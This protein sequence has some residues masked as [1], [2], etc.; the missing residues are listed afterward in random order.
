MKS[1]WEYF[2]SCFN[3]TK[4]YIRISGKKKAFLY[5]LRRKNLLSQFK[6][7][8]KWFLAP[9]FHYVV[10]FPTHL[11]IEAAVS[12]QMRCPMCKREQMPK[13]MKLGVMDFEL[14]K[15]IIDEASLRRVYS[16]KLSWRGEPLLNECLID[17]IK[18]AK[19]KGIQDVAFLTNGE[20][21]TPKLSMSLVESGLDWMSV[22]IDGMGEIYDR[23]R[24]PE[25]YEN[26]VKKIKFF[27]EYR[28][29]SGHK[30]PLIRIQTIWS[31]VK[32]DPDSYFKFFEALGDKVYIIADQQ[33]FDLAPFR[34][35]QKFKCPQPWQRM[36][37]GY[38]G[39]VTKCVGDYNE[40]DAIGDITKNSLYEIWHGEQMNKK[41][42]SVKQRGYLLKSCSTC[43]DSGEMEEKQVT[44]LGKK[45]KLNLYKGQCIPIEN[46][47]SRAE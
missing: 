6:D 39:I 30:K 14:F 24:W 29:K 32:D 4:D 3:D 47:D 46:I 26:I 41:R 23:I 11:E 20:R 19:Q 38:N 16:V 31:A 12:C 35:S 40:D 18:Y 2:T 8:A 34:R 10:D 42:K 37:V 45:V 5:F 15:K 28:D 25:I 27:K 44:I 1:I 22:S 7:R 33:R 17:M 36:A 21:L 43:N 13:D 9:V